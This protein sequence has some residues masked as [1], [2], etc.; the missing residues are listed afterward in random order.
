MIL[1]MPKKAR[2]HRIDGW[3]GYVVPRLAVA[4]CS[5]TG[6]SSDS[7]CKSTDAKAEIHRFQREV[8][9]PLG[10][11]SRTQMGASSNVF[12][13]KRWVVVQEKDFIVAAT[14]ALKWLAE[15]TADTRLIHDAGQRQ[16]EV[17]GEEQQKKQG[18]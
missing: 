18:A 17:R 5:D 8:L 12:C 15:H 9:Q 3:R 1:S 7:P 6:M 2:Y 4:G 14:A 11:K 10:I 16:L 13:G